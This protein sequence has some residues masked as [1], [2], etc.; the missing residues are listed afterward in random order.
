VTKTDEGETRL[1]IMNPNS[2]RMI[3]YAERMTIHS[4]SG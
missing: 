2:A 4:N 3:T 1:M